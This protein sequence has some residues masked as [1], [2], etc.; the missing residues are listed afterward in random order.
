MPLVRPEPAAP[1]SRVK[2]STTEPPKTSLKRPLKKKTKSL[3]ISLSSLIITYCRSKV[4]QNALLE[5][6]AI[7][8]TF[9]E[10]PFVFNTFVLSIFEWPLKTGFTVIFSCFC[11][12]LLTF[13][14]I[15]FLKNKFQEHY[16]SDKRFGFRSGP[17]FCWS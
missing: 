6:S 13:F 7:L 16:Q 2:H 15:N 5:H 10:L 4:L 17:K 9:I 3:F 14:K 11:C 8:S 1:Q 12:H